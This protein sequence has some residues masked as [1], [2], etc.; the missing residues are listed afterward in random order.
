[1]GV[2]R[3]NHC[4]EC[5]PGLN[6]SY[7]HVK[8]INGMCLYKIQCGERAEYTARWTCM[9]KGGSWLIDSSEAR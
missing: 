5:S 2:V 1:M 6:T 8:Y 7:P 3:V 4:P 9:C